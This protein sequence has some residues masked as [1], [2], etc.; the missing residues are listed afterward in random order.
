[1]IRLSFRISFSSSDFGGRPGWGRESHFGRVGLLAAASLWSGLAPAAEKASTESPAEV[2]LSYSSDVGCPKRAQ[3]LEEVTA[4]VR[5]PVRFETPG[6]TVRMVVKLERRG[7]QALGKLDIVQ[8]PGEPTRREFS[9]ASCDEVGSALALVAALALDPNARTEPL[10]AP[11]PESAATRPSADSTSPGPSS[12][13]APVE[14]QRTATRPSRS[15]VAAPSTSTSGARHAVWIGPRAELRLGQAPE[16]VGLIGAAL[17]ARTTL[18]DLSPSVQLTPAWGKTGATGPE[19]PQASFAWALGRLDLC[20]HSPRLGSRARL[21]PCA[22]AEVGRLTARGAPAAIADP[23]SVERWWVAG[24]AT[25]SLAFDFR[26][27]FFGL[28][29]SSLFPLTRDRFVFG[30]PGGA[31]RFVHQ[32][33][34]VVLGLDAG[35]GFLWDD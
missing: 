27:W 7:E 10:P 20:P 2:T 34:A 26:G 21:L 25:V 35:V 1:M 29:V 4:R 12:P 3:F 13:E 6:A 19:S 18:G 15:A 9:A 31:D 5:R 11:Q 28:G 22:V 8:A 32:A 24:G 17:G 14:V 23:S 16:V 30:Q 33:S